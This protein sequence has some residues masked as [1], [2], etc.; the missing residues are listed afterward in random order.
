M[1]E[2]TRKKQLAIHK[3]AEELKEKNYLKMNK[4]HYMRE[5]AEQK[6]E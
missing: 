1:N 6:V 4:I 2:C 5:L 3:Q